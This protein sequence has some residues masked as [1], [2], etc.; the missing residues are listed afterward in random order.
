MFDRMQMVYIS[1]V[2][3]QNIFT[4]HCPVFILDASVKPSKS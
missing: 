2:K 3:I 1:S 4:K